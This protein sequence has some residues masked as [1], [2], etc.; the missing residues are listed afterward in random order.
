MILTEMSEIKM[1]SWKFKLNYKN[2]VHKFKD[3]FLWFGKS[4]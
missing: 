2:F 1:L 4:Q 3:D